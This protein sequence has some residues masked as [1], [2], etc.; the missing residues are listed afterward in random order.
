M[1]SSEVILLNDYTATKKF[2]I[3]EFYNELTR[4]AAPPLPAGDFTDIYSYIPSRDIAAHCREIK[5]EFNSLEQ[6]FI[7]YLSN[8]TLA[9]KHKAW[10]NIIETQ[11]NMELPEEFDRPGYDSLHQ[12]LIDYMELE[13]QT[14]ETLK[15]N[16]PNVA[17][18]CGFDDNSG[19]DELFA[20]WESALDFIQKENED[21]DEYILCQ[22]SKRWF[23]KENRRLTVKIDPDGEVTAFDVFWYEVFECGSNEYYLASR[24]SDIWVK[25]PAPFKK[26][27]IVMGEAPAYSVHEPFV[28]TSVSES[29]SDWSD[30]TAYGYWVNNDGGIY[31]ECMHAY[32]NLEYYREE[33]TGK[34]RILKAISSHI[35]GELR[36]DELMNAYDVILHEE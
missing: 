13:H 6:A 7:V 16:E 15:V 22:V 28:L 32:Q 2:Q 4:F 19:H 24:I 3:S 35:K 29:G 27:D 11:P 23:G 17:Y 36:V 33:L 31:H 26:G 14:I 9:D 21:E 12:F 34:N 1:N 20:T 30:M 18:S 5:H 10:Q 25:I 8:K